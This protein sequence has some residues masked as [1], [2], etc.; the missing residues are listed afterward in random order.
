MDLKQD[1]ED[2]LDQDSI[3]MIW[4]PWIEFINI[5]RDVESLK[6]PNSK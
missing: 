1:K 6:A 5:P 4:Y 3:D 2:F